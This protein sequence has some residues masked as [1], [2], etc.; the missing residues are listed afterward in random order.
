M[1]LIIDLTFDLGCKKPF[2]MLKQVVD[3]LWELLWV[4]KRWD[5]LAQK[6][7]AEGSAQSGLL[8]WREVISEIQEA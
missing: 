1:S 3:F 7:K 8:K 4:I 2:E 6:E 5:F